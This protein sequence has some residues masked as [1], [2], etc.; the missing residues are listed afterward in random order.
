MREVVVF[1]PMASMVPGSHSA[2][3]YRILTVK[4]MNM[5]VNTVDRTQQKRLMVQTL[6]LESLGAKPG[7]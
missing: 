6:E 1:G 5:D 4:R 2:L 7:C 3:A